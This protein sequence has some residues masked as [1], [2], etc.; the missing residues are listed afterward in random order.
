MQKTIRETNDR[1]N[2]IWEILDKIKEQYKL[3]GISRETL[4]A[5]NQYAEIID[6]E[7]YDDQKFKITCNW[8]EKSDFIRK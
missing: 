4:E 2:P 5:L 7:I 8:G 6:K 3:S 1:D